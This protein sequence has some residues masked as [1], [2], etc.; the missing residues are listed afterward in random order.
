[1]EEETPPVRATAVYVPP[2]DIEELKKVFAEILQ[3]GQLTLGRQTAAFEA[4]FARVLGVP[5]AIAVNSGTSALEITLRAW[6]L[7]DQEIVVPTNTF[8]A[9]AFAVLHSGNRVVLAD[10]GPDFCL[11]LE[12]L[13]NAVSARTKAVVLVHIGGLV[14]GD[15]NRIADFCRE[16]GI[17]LLEDAAHAHGSTL[18]GRLAG[19]FGM[20]AG[21]SFYPTKVMTSG[22]GGMIVTSDPR[23]AETAKVLRDQGKAGF[24]TNLHVELGY[25][26]R[27]SELHAA[28][29]LAQLRKLGQFIEHR[30]GIARVYDQGLKGLGHIT[31]LPIAN[32]VRSNY[33][34]YIAML[35]DSLDR[36]GLK[37]RL[38]QSLK[39]SLAGEVYDV[40]L[41]HQPVFE[42]LGLGRG[43]EF[44]TAEDVC[45]R[46]ICLPMSAVMTGADAR[47]VVDGLKEVESW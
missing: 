31:P 40:P 20:A 7:V 33:Y 16:R 43:R 25:N 1:M 34:K 5:D 8:A 23:L 36:D 26:W 29:G 28:L 21:F 27:L 22:E 2:E 30:R 11:S 41:H 12:T 24:T 13:E 9:T 10:V 35:D 18:G 3:T 37:S 39:I 32:D 38:R 47:R 15:S 42:R 44:P 19:T 17:L 14:A 4:E 6:H 46:H 45:R